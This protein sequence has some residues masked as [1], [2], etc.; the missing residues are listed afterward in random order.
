MLSEIEGENRLDYLGST[1]AGAEVFEEFEGDIL[2]KTS[3]ILKTQPEHITKTINRFLKE[4]QD[5]VK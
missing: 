2:A 4:L 5:K 3:E 1:V